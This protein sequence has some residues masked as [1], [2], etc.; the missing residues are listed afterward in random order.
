MS[1]AF[2][3]QQV[4]SPGAYQ[5]LGSPPLQSSSYFGSMQ[6]PTTGFNAFQ[7]QQLGAYG[8][9]M[10]GI[11]PGIVSGTSRTV[12]L[13]NIPPDTSAEEILGHVRSG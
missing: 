13:G 8:T 12:Y 4:L 3:Q 7:G 11:S 2:G 6:S 5:P 1:Q 10:H 9:A